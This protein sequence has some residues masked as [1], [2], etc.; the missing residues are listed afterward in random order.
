MIG[1]DPGS[2]SLYYANYGTRVEA[3]S[4]FAPG[5]KAPEK[6]SASLC[7]S[8]EV[9]ASLDQTAWRMK[10]SPC[11]VVWVFLD[12]GRRVDDLCRLTRENVM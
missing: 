6:A 7:P 11:A 2:H 9:Q 10:R 4:R 8:G 1:I 12:T 3:A 5:A